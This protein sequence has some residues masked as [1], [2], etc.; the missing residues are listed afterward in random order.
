MA[1]NVNFNGLQDAIN[2]ELRLYADSVMS[3][4]EKVEKK[5]S[6]NAVKRLRVAGS[7]DNQRQGKNYRKGWRARKNGNNGYI[8]YNATNYQ[9]THLLEYGHATR[10]GGRTRAFPHIRPVEQEVIKEFESQIRSALS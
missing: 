6:N 10:N 7:F 1:R 2:R 3:E 9:L 4:I 5:V 8:I